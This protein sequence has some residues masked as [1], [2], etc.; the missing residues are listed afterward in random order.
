VIEKDETMKDH[1]EL[2]LDKKQIIFTD[3]LKSDIEKELKKRNID[4][5]STLII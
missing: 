1:L 5:V 2:I 4:S 3:I